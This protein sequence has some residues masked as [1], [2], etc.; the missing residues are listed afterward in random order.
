M[1][2]QY[3]PWYYTTCNTNHIMIVSI[4]IDFKGWKKD[5]SY[6]STSL[7]TESIKTTLFPTDYN[8]CLGLIINE[9]KLKTIFWLLK[10]NVLKKKLQAQ[11]KLYPLL[12]LRWKQNPTTEQS[13][14]FKGISGLFG[15]PTLT[16]GNFTR[17]QMKVNKWLSMDA[18]T[19]FSVS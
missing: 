11:F 9:Q 1:W 19:F 13:I 2:Q 10:W 6:F 5:K 15:P 16:K 7:F 17:I 14:R 12:A 8:I 18:V 4:N 3:S